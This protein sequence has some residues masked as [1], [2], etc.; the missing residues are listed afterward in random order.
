[1]AIFVNTSEKKG[2]TKIEPF[3]GQWDGPGFRCLLLNLKLRL[4]S[5]TRMVGGEKRLKKVDL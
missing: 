2:K 3:W 1:M 5:W 4:V